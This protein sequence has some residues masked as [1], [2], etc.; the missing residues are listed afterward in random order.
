MIQLGISDHSIIYAVRKLIIPKSNP[1]IKIVRNFKNFNA[2]DFLRD[3]S[4][5]PWET[6]VIQDNANTCWK[7]WKSFYL[8]VLDRHAPFR[9]V[10]IRGNSIPWVTSDIEKLMRLRDYHK[11]RAVKF[12][13]QF[14]WDKFKETRN[15][16]NS[17][18]RTTKRNYFCNEINDSVQSNDIKRSWSLINTLLGKQNKNYTSIKELIIDDAIISDEQSIAES[19]NNFFVNIGAKLASEIDDL[20]HEES[21]NNLS[22]TIESIFK[23]SEI[24]T[25]EIISEIRNLKASKSTGIDNIP[26][27]VL[28]LSAD[29][30]GPSIAKIFN[31]SLKSGFFVHEW[32]MASVLPIYK[33]DDKRKCENYR[34]ISILP[35]ISKIFER[36]VFNQVYSYLNDNWLLSKYQA[37]FRPKNSTMAALIQ[38]CDEWYANMDKGKLNGVV[39]LDIRKAFD[40]IN[41]N[42]LLEKLETQFGIPNNELKWFKSYLT[43][44]EQ[45]CAINGHLSSPQKI[46][47]GIPHGSILGHLLF[48]LY[49]NDLP[50][51]LKEST[52]CLYADDTQIFSSSYDYN[53]L[54]DKLNSDLINISDWLARN[55]LQYHPTKTK[56]MIIGSTYNLNNKVHN[57]PVILNNKPLSRTSTFECVGVLLDEKL[58]WDKHIDKILKKVGSGIAMLR[59]AKKFIPTSSL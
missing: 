25:L 40:S 8:G 31:I 22:Q 3:L 4:Q 11:K 27:K 52:P 38:M 50:T 51:S 24:S 37:G 17:C 45:V 35:I 33:T 1:K 47:C 21:T 46:V 5:I 42:I 14:H 28:K 39:F 34:P 30:I 16:L 41:H 58:K 18:L 10:R 13:S 7:I 57:K 44:R 26:A 15:K 20:P 32:K 12:N 59:R 19:F 23:F 9:R 54:I 48:L 36:S 49:I 53:E 6:T 2:N 56:F 55:K 29:I 43:N